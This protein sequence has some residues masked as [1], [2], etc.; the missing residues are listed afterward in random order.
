MAYCPMAE[1]DERLAIAKTLLQSLNFHW[2]EYGDANSFDESARMIAVALDAE[3]Q[4]GR[5]EAAA[6]ARAHR[7]SAAR[8]R[9]ELGGT[10]RYMLPAA[11]AT[12][13]AE[14]RGEDIAAEV[15]ERAILALGDP[16]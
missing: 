13:Q 2:V 9:D 7:G 12:I 1:P 14:E 6:I 3:R 8:R 15:I 4:A 10:L 5:E 11:V 16:A